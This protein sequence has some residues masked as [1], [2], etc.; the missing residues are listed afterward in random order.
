M[1]RETSQFA[2]LIRSGDT[3]ARI[4]VALAS[5]ATYATLHCESCRK[6][7][8]HSLAHVTAPGGAWTRFTCGG[9]GHTEDYR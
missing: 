8:K 9:C 4:R 6:D 3:R 2:Q 1:T 7:T 5:T